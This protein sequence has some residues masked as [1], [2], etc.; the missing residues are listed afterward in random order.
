MGKY[1]KKESKA[2]KRADV[3][4]NGGTLKG[5]DARKAARQGGV[6]NGVVNDAQGRVVRDLSARRRKPTNVHDV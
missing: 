4:A 2:V 6:D 1:G 3:A 5:K